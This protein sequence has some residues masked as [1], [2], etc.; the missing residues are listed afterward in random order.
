MLFEKEREGKGGKGKEREMD[1]LI[2]AETPPPLNKCVT[3]LCATGVKSRYVKDC[4]L[5]Y[6]IST[7]SIPLL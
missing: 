1:V 7:P 2:S 4:L 6:Q 5:V 3:I